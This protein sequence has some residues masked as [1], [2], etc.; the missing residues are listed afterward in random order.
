MSLSQL[1]KIIGNYM[2]QT[3]VPNV[4]NALVKRE[5]GN[6]PPNPFLYWEGNWGKRGV[7]DLILRLKGVG[8]RRNQKR[9]ERHEPYAAE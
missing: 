4:S 3:N 7:P 8:A 6:T 9:K 1:L 5:L 2:A